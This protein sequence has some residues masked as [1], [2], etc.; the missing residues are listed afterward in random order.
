MRSN[1]AEFDE[2]S[3]AKMVEEIMEENSQFEVCGK[4]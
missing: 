3:G 1:L 4:Q 2:C